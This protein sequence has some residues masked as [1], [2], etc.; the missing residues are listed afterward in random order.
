LLGGKYR[1]ERPIGEGGMGQIFQAM[2]VALGQAV[3]IKIMRPDRASD[4]DAIERFLREARAGVMLKSSHVAR[5]FDVAR[6]PEGVPYI[7]MELLV[8]KNLVTL[9]SESGALPYRDSVD[10]I[11]QA[12]DAVGEAHRCGIVHRDL[13]PENLFLTRRRDGSPQVKVLDFG[14]S[15]VGEDVA[16]P[17][18]QRLLTQDNTVLG[19][20][21]YMSPEQVKNSNRVDAR[22]DIWSLGVSLYEL[23]TAAEPFAAHSIAE[24]FANVLTATPVSPSVMRDDIPQGLSTI[25]LCCLEKDPDR[26]FQTV[27]ELTEALLPF[28]SGRPT[29]VSPTFRAEE[30]SSTLLS[31]LTSL[32]S[33][34]HLKGVSDAS[35]ASTTLDAE[36]LSPAPMS[37]SATIVERVPSRR[38]RQAV[39]L[40]SLAG[41]LLIVVASFASRAFVRTSPRA[42]AAGGR[43]AFVERP[44]VSPKPQASHEEGERADAPDAGAVSAA[45]ATSRSTTLPRV[46]ASQGPAARA[47]ASPRMPRER[48][49]W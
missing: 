8:G 33:T 46:S 44:Q 6:T 19:T 5:V 38:V 45:P 15:K 47:S 16:R 20:P 25:V 26:R 32:S 10:V 36:P 21:S 3:A 39:V 1:I 49:P 30:S 35:A 43:A 14:I 17:S 42:V 28:G 2:H 4:P 34:L 7:V 24:I 27:D 9:V 31:R 22:S 12:C 11:L 37:L 18:S 48:T 23:L 40:V 29:S 13:K 41:V